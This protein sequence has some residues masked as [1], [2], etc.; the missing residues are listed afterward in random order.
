LLRLFGAK[1]GRHVQIHPSV[2]I[3]LPWNLEVGE[4]SSIGFDALVYNL[5]RVTIGERVTI[6]QRA[7]LC[8]GSHDYRDRAMVLLK[9]PICVGDGAWICA[10]AFVGPGVTVGEGAV[11]GARSVVMR[12]VEKNAVMAGNPARRV[13]DKGKSTSR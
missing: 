13:A 2:R 4:W 5:G 9:P 11:L 6:S 8:A 7:H 1:I 10:D 3:F 12:N